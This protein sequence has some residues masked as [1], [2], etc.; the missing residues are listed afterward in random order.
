MSFSSSC[1]RR[2]IGVDE[3][4]ESK[5]MVNRGLGQDAVAEVENMSGLPGVLIEDSPGLEFELGERC[6]QGDWV[7]VSLNVDLGT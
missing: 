2:L 7:K 4:D 1:R 5:D 6:K 3:V